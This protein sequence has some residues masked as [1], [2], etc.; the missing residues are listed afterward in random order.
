MYRSTIATW[1]EE[2]GTSGDGE[3]GADGFRRL[4]ESRYEGT[5]AALEKT[6]VEK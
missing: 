2:G 6:V 5:G 4:R 1:I 3:E